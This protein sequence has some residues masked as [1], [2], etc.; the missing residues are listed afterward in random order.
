MKEHFLQLFRY[1][2]WATARVLDAMKQLPVQDEK[3]LEWMAHILLAQQIW[4][5]RLTG[6]QGPRSGWEKKTLIECFSMYNGNMQEWEEYCQ[7]LDESF[8]TKTVKYKTLDGKDFESSVK[9]IL[10]HVINHSTYHRGQII[11]KLKG[12]LPTLPSTDFIFYLREKS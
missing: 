4:Y 11:A 12:Q 2:K 10:T 8:L 6:N 5:S 1:E 9:D 7:Q 3:C